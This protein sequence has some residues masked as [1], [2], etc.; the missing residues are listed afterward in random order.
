MKDDSENKHT[1]KFHDPSDFINEP[2]ECVYGPPP[3]REDEERE[4]IDEPIGCVYGPPPP[5]A[6]ET[7]STGK[8]WKNLLKTIFTRLFHKD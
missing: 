3:V 5:P 4:L 8:K 7:E 6:M 1:H 2:M